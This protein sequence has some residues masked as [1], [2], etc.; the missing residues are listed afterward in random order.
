MD[1]INLGKSVEIIIWIPAAEFAG[2]SINDSIDSPFWETAW[3]FVW[4]C[5]W[6]PI[7]N[8]VYGV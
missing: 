8:A 7:F 4:H 6:D 5:T 1:K 2:H 3:E